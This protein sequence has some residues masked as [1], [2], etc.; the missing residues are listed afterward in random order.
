MA[1][2]FPSHPL[3]LVACPSPS[4]RHTGGVALFFPRGES[5]AAA[6]GQEARGK[7]QGARRQDGWEKKTA[8]CK[9]ASPFPPLVDCSPLSVSRS[10]S[11]LPCKPTLD[12]AATQDSQSAAD[13]GEAP[14]S[15]PS[16]RP[17]FFTSPRCAG[18]KD[19]HFSF[20]LWKTL[21]PQGTSRQKETVKSRLAHEHFSSPVPANCSPLSLGQSASC[22]LCKPTLD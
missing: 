11:C 20:S 21:L 19:C 17:F 1:G 16:H 9:G 7:G 18:K 2:S 12:W 14:C 15:L 5:P 4:P 8:L 10:A 3:T 6:G 22:L 13:G